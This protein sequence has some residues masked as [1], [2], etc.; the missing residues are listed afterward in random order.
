[1]PITAVQIK[2]FFICL[3]LSFSSTQVLLSQIPSCCRPGSSNFQQSTM[4][5]HHH[6]AEAD[7]SESKKDEE[8]QDKMWR[9]KAT[10]CHCKSLSLF[11]LGIKPFIAD[12]TV[13]YVPEPD[14]YAVLPLAH[15]FAT[16]S[17]VYMTVRTKPPQLFS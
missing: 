1:M 14:S 8:T 2:T 10:L 12:Q 9:G 17:D 6:V 7:L 4:S 3:L 13:L 5:C 11:L 16:P 15:S